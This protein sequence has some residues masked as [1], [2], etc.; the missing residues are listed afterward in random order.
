[1]GIYRAPQRGN[2]VAKK[3]Q[4]KPILK[5]AHWTSDVDSLAWH[6]VWDFAR[7][8]GLD[9]RRVSNKLSMLKAAQLARKKGM[10]VSLLVY[11][12]HDKS[13]K[14]GPVLSAAFAYCWDVCGKPRSGFQL[15]AVVRA[16]DI[17]R[18]L[19]DPKLGDNDVLLAIEKIVDASYERREA[20]KRV[21]T[22]EV[23]ARE[24]T[25]LRSSR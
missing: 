20:L 15:P 13:N 23:Q 8:V 24:R 18:L 12:D 5:V 25:W 9:E 19:S 6:A 1:M 21:H 22:F 11:D 7:L 2:S 4:R 17:D 16:S 3:K 14:N 10:K